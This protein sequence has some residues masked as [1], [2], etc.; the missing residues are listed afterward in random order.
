MLSGISRQRLEDG[1]CMPRDS[2]VDPS[3]PI[4]HL[5]LKQIEKCILDQVSV[6]VPFKEHRE[7]EKCL[8]I[9]LLTLS[10]RSPKP[11]TDHDILGH[12]WQQVIDVFLLV[13]II[14]VTKLFTKRSVIGII[15][16]EP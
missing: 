6:G 9:T 5:P 10:P 2:Q 7:M 15:D 8:K 4:V 1:I 16:S 12:Y 11:R 13:V 3:I 14:Q